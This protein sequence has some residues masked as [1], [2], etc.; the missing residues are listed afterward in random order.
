[1][2]IQTTHR[3]KPEPR[4]LE[5]FA[6]VYYSVL[7]EVQLY[8]FWTFCSATFLTKQKKTPSSDTNLGPVIVILKATRSVCVCVCVCVCVSVPFS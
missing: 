1:M 3:L 8:S 6:N 4:Y 5:L 2:Y 7:K